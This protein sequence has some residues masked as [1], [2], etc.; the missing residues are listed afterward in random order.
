MHY[1][2]WDVESANVIDIYRTESEGLAMVR[3]L[4]A[5]GWD[6][7]HLALGLDFDEGE[8]A[9]DARLP[10]VL[11]G[12]ALVRRAYEVEVGNDRLAM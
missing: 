12:A 6:P 9:D 3:S 4:L 11:Q 10:P 2:L 8:N 5:A 1:Q 7:E